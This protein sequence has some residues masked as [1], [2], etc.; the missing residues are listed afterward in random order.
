[1]LLIFLFIEFIIYMAII[2][3]RYMKKLLKGQDNIELLSDEL[4]W[5]TI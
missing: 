5:F 4:N 3:Q 1:M 2:E